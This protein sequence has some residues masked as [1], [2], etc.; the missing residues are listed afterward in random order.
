MYHFIVRH[1]VKTIFRHL[2][3]GDFGFILRQ[4][5]PTAEHW[6]SGRHALSGQRRTPELRQQW[7]RR[8]EA[9]FPGIQFDVQKI[10]VS[11]WPWQTHVAVEWKDR[12]FDAA[13][14]ALPSNQGIF[15]LTLRWGR[16]VEFHV[17]CDTQILTESLQVIARQGVSQAAEPPLSERVASP[18]P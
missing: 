14:A 8:L 17:Y 10:V 13:G 9:V 2:N 6:F 1:R 15:M 3:R 4:F 5:A 12:V 16:A 18:A 11:G 7:Y